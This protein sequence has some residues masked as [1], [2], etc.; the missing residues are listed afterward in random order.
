M[1]CRTCSHSVL[2]LH[3][4]QAR[5]VLQR[6]RRR[7]RRQP[8]CAIFTA[9]S[10]W[11]RASL[12]HGAQVK[13]DIEHIKLAHFSHGINKKSKRDKEKEAADAK[14]LQEEHEAARAYAEFVDAFDSEPSATKRAAAFVRAGEAPQPAHRHARPMSTQAMFDDGVRARAPCVSCSLTRLSGLHLHQ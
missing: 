1:S 6:R 13:K 11:C 8:A 7:R 3:Y 4:E 2:V 9:L 10:E 12:A 5:R 14:K